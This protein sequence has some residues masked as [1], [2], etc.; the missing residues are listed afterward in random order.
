MQSNDSIEYIFVKRKILS[1]LLCIFCRE[2]NMGQKVDWAIFF[3]LLLYKK[4]LD[5]LIYIVAYW[6]IS[7]WNHL[8]FYKQISIVVKTISMFYCPCRYYNRIIAIIALENVRFTK[9]FDICG[10]LSFD[11][12]LLLISCISILCFACK[13]FGELY[14]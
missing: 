12:M 1:I 4:Y 14:M 13:T 8:K 6:R 7:Y 9:H 5:F 10:L 2:G 11:L 3:L